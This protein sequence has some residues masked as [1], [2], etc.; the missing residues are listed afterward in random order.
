MRKEEFI[1]QKQKVEEQLFIDNFLSQKTGVRYWFSPTKEAYDV[2]IVSGSSL[3][4]CETKVR[5]K[6][7]SFF[8]KYGP[9]LEHKKIMGMSKKRDEA[10]E[11][12]KNVDMLY[13][14]FCTDELHIYKLE[15][16]FNYQ[17]WEPRLLPK[18]NYE[19]H[20]LVMKMVTTLPK[21]QIIETIK[22]K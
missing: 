8:M 10:R 13:F 20:I 18:D 14:N 2:Q 22:I 1:E 9:F 6:D 5:T 11:K 7:A 3:F 4:L 12:G 17:V 19:P 21:S 15:D 16:W